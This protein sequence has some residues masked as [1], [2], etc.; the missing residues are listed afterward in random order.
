MGGGA[1]SNRRR[2]SDAISCR[3]C[4]LQVLRLA[5]VMQPL[6]KGSCRPLL[7]PN[8]LHL[9]ERYNLQLRQKLLEI[10][11]QTQ[12]RP[13][14]TTLPPNPD[15]Q[16]HRTRHPSACSTAVLSSIAWQTQTDSPQ[17]EARPGLPSGWGACLGHAASI[18]PQ[19]PAEHCGRRSRSPL[20]WATRA[21]R[22]PG[23]WGR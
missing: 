22:R 9:L 16:T 13:L 14:L 8:V 2:G 7:R 3:S 19:G 17:A 12:S 20:L 4:L 23:I 15:I 10:G 11:K 21:S 6:R 18:A 5:A 1:E